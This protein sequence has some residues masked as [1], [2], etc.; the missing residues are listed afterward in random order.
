MSEMTKDL[1]KAER[2]RANVNFIV[3]DIQGGRSKPK[4]YK[5]DLTMPL[6]LYEEMR[7]QGRIRPEDYF[8]DESAFFEFTDTEATIS[9]INLWSC[10]DMLHKIDRYLI[11]K[12]AGSY[13]IKRGGRMF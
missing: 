12:F 8:V 4:K 9:F 5:H 10:E 7:D 2:R 6:F 3:D 11:I 1:M 13:P